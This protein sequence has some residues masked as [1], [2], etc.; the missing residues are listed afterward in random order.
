MVHQSLMRRS[1]WNTMRMRLLTV[2][3]VIHVAPAELKQ[4]AASRLHSNSLVD[5][6]AHMSGDKGRAL[7][8]I[9]LSSDGDVLAAMDRTPHL[10]RASLEARHT[11][12]LMQNSKKGWLP[13]R[14][15]IPLSKEMSPKT[16]QEIEDMNSFEL[17][18][19]R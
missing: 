17:V 14:H 7:A 13:F 5:E 6:R 16:P 19:V 10:D 4:M 1:M 3:S 8:F 12:I 18:R 11:F 9:D 2:D 15:R